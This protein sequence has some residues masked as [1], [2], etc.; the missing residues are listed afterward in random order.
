MPARIRAAALSGYIPTAASVGLDPY[1]MLRRQKLGPHLLEQPEHPIPLAA[2]D[3]LL[4]E[5]ARQSGCGDFG[6]RLAESRTLGSL[7]PLAV[8]LAQETSCREVIEHLIRFQRLLSEAV[9]YS[10]E[11]SGDV[12]IFRTEFAGSPV[13]RQLVEC[14]MALTFRIVHDFLRV[15]WLPESAHFAH[16][17]PR[18]VRAHARIF[19]CAL[20]F[21]SP[22]NGFVCTPESLEARREGGDPEL[23]AEAFR[24]VDSLL[25]RAGDHSLEGRARRAIHLMLPMGGA[26]LEQVA[27]A[28]DMSPRTFQRTLE[29]QAISFRHLLNQVRCEI[30]SGYL[31]KPGHTV[32]SAAQLTGFAT[33]T[34][35]TRW[36]REQFSQAPSAWRSDALQ[37]P[38]EGDSLVQRRSS[39]AKR[40]F[41][42]SSRI[43]QANLSVARSGDLGDANV[44]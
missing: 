22:F 36:F 25:T 6:L 2:L 26:T 38:D 32:A 31:A 30:A 42:G 12:C 19:R 29:D 35:F 9:S 18:D 34:A 39:T 37:P 27:W 14:M 17:A 43:S 33:P 28:I 21:E 13:G 4:E 41:N 44:E 1:A 8:L 10:L 5:S 7:G 23:A 20:Q 40:K 11:R 15:P 3:S 16:P 24:M